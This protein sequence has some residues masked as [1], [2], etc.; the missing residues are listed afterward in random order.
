MNRNEAK[1]LAQELTDMGYMLIN[2]ENIGIH[3]PDPES[4]TKGGLI[5]PDTAKVKSL[6]G[7]VIMRGDAVPGT[8]ELGDAVTFVRYNT[9][10]IKV[11]RKDGT[12][13]VVHVM[14][15]KDVYIRW[16]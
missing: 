1:A 6:V 14:H 2:D 15:Y 8:L 4:K 7:R 13:I 9:A 5:I 11:R 12:D 3:R 10:E 16:K